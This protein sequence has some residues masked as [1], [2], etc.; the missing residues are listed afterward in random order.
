MDK[1]NQYLTSV[2][3]CGNEIEDLKLKIEDFW[4]AYGEIILKFSVFIFLTRVKSV[5]DYPGF[6][7]FL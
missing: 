4:N 2:K 7:G 3:Q 1:Q 6:K 5:S